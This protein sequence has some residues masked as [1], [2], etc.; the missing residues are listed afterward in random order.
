MAI[1]NVVLGD[2]EMGLLSIARTFPNNITSIIT[3]IAPIYAPVFIAFYA[4]DNFKEL[5]V[6][7]KESIRTSAIIMFVPIT[8]FIVYSSDFYSLWQKS[9]S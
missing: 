1:A 9:L 3:T 8:G 5:I 6:K 7:I 4:K 2:Y